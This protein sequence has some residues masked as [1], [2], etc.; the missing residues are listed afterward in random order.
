VAVRRALRCVGLL[1]VGVVVAAVLIQASGE[2]ARAAGGPRTV[3]SARQG[4]SIPEPPPTSTPQSPGIELT[5]ASFDLPDPFLLDVKGR[6][7]LYVS[8]MFF[9]ENQNIPVLQEANGRWSHSSVDAVPKLPNWAEGNPNGGGLSWSPTV[10][11]LGRTYVMYFA[12]TILGSDPVHHCI[13]L[14][15]STS[16]LGPFTVQANPFVCQPAFGGDI[17]AAMFVDKNG[18]DGPAHPDY[19]VWKS[20]D[21]S[22]P[23]GGATHIWA[24]PLSNDGRHLLGQPVQIYSPDQTWEDNLVEAPQMTLSPDGNVWL[25]FSAGAGVGNPSYGMGV[26]HCSGPL[27]PCSGG[28]ANPLLTSN[29]QGQGPGEETYFTAKDGSDWLLYN[30]WYTGDPLALIRPVEAVRIGWSPAGPYVAT[31]G[32]FP[33]P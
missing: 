15:T 18:P 22:M 11:R 8:S 20:D 17:D 7:Y 1:A 6:Y 14:A 29:Q 5:Q 19:L 4:A 27:G 21:N 23:D 9:G 2:T 13:A 33:R 16:P 3:R 25:F 26:V 28:D 12:P 30:P 31:A 32:T 24:Q 10:Y